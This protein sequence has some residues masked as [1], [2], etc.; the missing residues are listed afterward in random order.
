MVYKIVG[1]MVGRT[2][3]FENARGEVV[4]VM[5]KTTKA[6]LKTAVFGSGSESTIDVAPGVDCSFILALVFAIGQVGAHFLKDCFGNFVQDPI[7]DAAVESAAGAVT[8]GAIGDEGAVEELAA[9]V[10]LDD[11]LGEVVGGASDFAEGAAEAAGLGD[12]L[13][14]AMEGTAHFMSEAVGFFGDLFGE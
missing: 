13:E 9:T 7:Q 11:E 5:A 8:G 6:L 3:S 10:G 12:G 4:A 2:L 1:D 14:D